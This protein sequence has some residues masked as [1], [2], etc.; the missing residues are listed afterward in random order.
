MHLGGEHLL[1][2]AATLRFGDH[3]FQQAVADPQAAPVLEHRNAADV[4][5]GQQARGADGV[6]ALQSEEVDCVDVFRIP[7]LLRRHRLFGDEHGFADA[8]QVGIV[9]LPIGDADVYLTHRQTPDFL[10]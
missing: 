6:V 9:L 3:R 5:I 2:E 7:F 10:A 4:T 8:A 1:L